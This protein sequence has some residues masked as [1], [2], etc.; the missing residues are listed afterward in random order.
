MRS[1]AF[2]VLLLRT[3]NAQGVADSILTV[4]LA[5]DAPTE[6]QLSAALAAAIAPISPLPV[7]PTATD[8]GV[9]LDGL[10][11][12]GSPTASSSSSGLLG[13]LTADASPTAR[14]NNL[15]ASGG[16][17]GSG[18]FGGDGLLYDED[19]SGDYYGDDYGDGGDDETD[20]PSDCIC[21]EP[22]YG[23]ES[24]SMGAS[25]TPSLYARNKL[26]AR[27]A[28]SGGF[29]AFN[30]PGAS[31]NSRASDNSG[32][33]GNSDASLSSSDSSSSSIPTSSSTPTSS[34][35][36]TS[37]SFSLSSDA[38]ISIG[39]FVSSGGD[40]NVDLPGWL[41]D[42]TGRP[43][44]KS[45]CPKACCSQPTGKY[46]IDP[47]PT[48]SRPPRPSG[49][50]PAPSSYLPAPSAYF[51]IPSGYFPGPSSD[52]PAS[53]GYMPASS[54][55][56]PVPTGYTGSYVPTPTDEPWYDASSAVPSSDVA[57]DYAIPASTW[58]TLVSPPGT[59]DSYTPAPSADYTGD[60]LAGICPKTC[61][62]DDPAQNFCDITTSCTTTGG[63]KYYCACRAG[64]M[65]SAW[66]A[67][68]FSKQFHVDGQPYVYVAPG[69]VCDQVCDDQTCTAVLT[70]PACA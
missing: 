8:A 62:P 40:E 12:L 2:G 30:W 36:S 7:T 38:P 1:F 4:S 34:S 43:R 63:S 28:A 47:A 15:F 23:D 11:A 24:T 70:R 56:L 61:K 32:I 52:L 68:D 9:G 31:G 57:T 67:K 17:P 33:S 45:K 41:Y 20:C 35:P 69:V 16:T 26:R 29:A 50:L 13:I 53:S 5:S 19:D 51:P 55:Y 37:S 18:G 14:P 65:A 64:Y 49:Y 48:Y 6:S 58:T 60:T 46:P 21:D 54:E 39:T 3:L 22:A 25:P 59:A 44:P 66:N 42:I 27:Q 10:L